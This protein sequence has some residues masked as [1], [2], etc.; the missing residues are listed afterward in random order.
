MDNKD[1]MQRELMSK[2]AEL[3]SKHKRRLPPD[4]IHLRL[5]RDMDKAQKDTPVISKAVSYTHLLLTELHFR[6]ILLHFR[7]NRDFSRAHQYN[8]VRKDDER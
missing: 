5:R 2:L 7:E 3:E 6:R 8:K 4:D 1:K